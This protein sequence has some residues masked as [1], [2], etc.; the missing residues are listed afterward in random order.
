[1]YDNSTNLLLIR[2]GQASFGAADYDNLCENGQQQMNWLGQYLKQQAFP[3]KRLISGNLKRHQQSAALVKQHLGLDE[4][5]VDPQW[6]EFRFDQVICDYFRGS[7]PEHDGT[8]KGYWTVIRPAFAAW[9]R[10]EIP[11]VYQK[12]DQVCQGYVR[13]LEQLKGQRA[14][15]ITS[16][17]VIGALRYTLDQANPE[18]FAD[19]MNISL[20][21]AMQEIS[22]SQGLPLFENFNAVP[23]LISPQRRAYISHF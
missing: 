3:I 4:V 1:M 21:S 18:R 5:E 13:A 6:N 2:H 7:L 10:D 19:Y 22:W 23:H 9:A 17:G 15:V 8:R 16:S 12:F 14:A 20:N 11:H